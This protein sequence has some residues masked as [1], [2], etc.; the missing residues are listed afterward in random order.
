VVGAL[1]ASAAAGGTHES[2]P[3]R[4]YGNRAGSV[5]SDLSFGSPLHPHAAASP[6]PPGSAGGRQQWEWESDKNAVECLRCVA[7]FTF[8]NRRHHCRTCGRIFCAKCSSRKIAGRRACDWCVAR[9]FGGLAPDGLNIPDRDAPVVASPTALASAG[10]GGSGGG[11]AV[12]MAGGV[13]AAHRHQSHPM[14]GPVGAAANPVSVSLAGPTLHRRSVPLSGPTP[15]AVADMR[16]SDRLARI[17]SVDSSDS[18]RAPDA[19]APEREQ[20]RAPQLSLPDA[21]DDA[22]DAALP[23]PRKA[24]DAPAAAAAPLFVD[25]AVG[26]LQSHVRGP[27]HDTLAASQPGGDGAGTG[28]D[29]ADMG[30]EAAGGP[31]M[32]AVA[33][34]AVAE[35][36]KRMKRLETRLRRVEAEANAAAV[37]PESRMPDPIAILGT[38]DLMA[39]CIYYPLAYLVA[40]AEW[41]LVPAGLLLVSGPRVLGLLWDLALHARSAAA[42]SSALVSLTAWL[43]P[44]ALAA[45][46]WFVAHSP[47][48]KHQLLRRQLVVFAV[49]AVAFLDYRITRLLS[50]KAVEEGGPSRAGADVAAAAASA[51]KGSSNS[52]SSAAAPAPASASAAAAPL[53]E[54]EDTASEGADGDAGSDD[55]EEDDE[56]GFLPTAKLLPSN[57]AWEAAHRRNAL[58]FLRLIVSLKGL[59]VKCGQYMSSRPDVCPA[60]YIRS[61]RALQDAMPA[62]P[63]AEVRAVMEEELGC[64]IDTLFAAV[65]ETAL[66]SASIG[67][68]HRARL[69]AD[70]SLV[71]VKVQ[72]KGMGTVIRQDL[73]TMDMLLGLLARLEKSLASTVRG[74]MDEWLKEVGGELDFNR[75]AANMTM[76]RENLGRTRLP[77]T[78]PQVLHLGAKPPCGPVADPM[79]DGARVLIMRFIPGV[80]ANDVPALDRLG[81][82]REALCDR[83]CRS[84]AQ[85]IYRDG[86]FNGDPH[87][88]N[89]MVIRRSVLLALQASNASKTV[90]AGAAKAPTDPEAARFRRLERDADT[91][92][93]RRVREL[94]RLTPSL[95]STEARE[96]ADADLR[97]RCRGYA[98]HAGDPWVPVLLDFGL[99]KRLSR[100]IRVSFCRL[101][102]AAEEIDFGGML[103]AMDGM[104]M[105]FSRE[106]AAEDLENLQYMFRDATPAK[107]AR[108]KYD[109][110]AK[111]KA[112]QR[113]KDKAA[114][115]QP[116]REMTAWPSDLMFY[117][118]ASEL[119]QGLC[120]HLG[121]RYPFMHTSAHAARLAF[122]VD[123]HYTTATG[124]QRPKRDCWARTRIY[125]RS[126]NNVRIISSYAFVLS[127]DFCLCGRDEPGDSQ[128]SMDYREG[129]SMSDPISA[130]TF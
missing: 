74:V 128:I 13:G 55:D 78:V 29:E 106:S 51:S 86:V 125:P 56:D 59:W 81:V 41:R 15:T 54:I 16:R 69:L 47:A 129:R 3:S 71:A 130:D 12:A 31:D 18:D 116:Q 39:S 98:D 117:L 87:P 114:A 93:Q 123:G 121:V 118:R 115:T 73:A 94:R 75:E 79:K 122:L 11:S 99:T 97:A 90:S 42:I 48:P 50:A 34:A 102:V 9:A 27:S 70:G 46:M 22:V 14:A 107:E 68:V 104:G 77:V 64:S 5:A 2:T 38:S 66:A 124:E 65:D 111:R 110:R 23:Q 8:V 62:R 28:I 127:L 126:T 53:A 91:R 103:E 108:A 24:T 30:E 120:S 6:L 49:A 35:V 96:Q 82:D 1:G 26:S 58:R 83:V 89:L 61:F 85:Q 36:D 95:A 92:L 32:G 57:L 19:T 67:Q 10:V 4:P 72:H 105:R 25:D 37:Y 33:A 52:K 88:G 109:E 17:P 76:V 63:L 84:Y 100:R 43:F 20:R 119:L 80:K 21:A 101:V 112:D 40:V 44:S 60:P 45:A 113:D 7:R